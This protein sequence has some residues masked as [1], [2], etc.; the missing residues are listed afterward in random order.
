MQRRLCSWNV[1]MTTAGL[2]VTLVF[3]IVKEQIP[4]AQL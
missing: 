2:I 4:S 1:A 3:M